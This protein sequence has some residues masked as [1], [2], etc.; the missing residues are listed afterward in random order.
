MAR[1][2]VRHGATF[3]WDCGVSYV[4]PSAA[5]LRQAASS[6]APTSTVG[7]PMPIA[8]AVATRMPGSTRNT[9]GWMT[10]L[11]G[12]TAPQGTGFRRRAAGYVERYGHPDAAPHLH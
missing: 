5:A 9:A 10:N 11:D 1:N 7:S 3:G 4:E 6:S 12:A 2:A 8:T